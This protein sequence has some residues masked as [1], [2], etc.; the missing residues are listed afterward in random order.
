MDLTK[1]SKI[2][3]ENIISKI[4]RGNST[5]FLD[6]KKIELVHNI[7]NKQHINHYI[8]YPYEGASYG[9]IYSN[10][11]P[12]IAVLKINTDG[13]LT[14]R[15][16]MGSLYSLNLKREIFGDI[17]IKD[18][19]YVIVMKHMAEYIKQNIYEI[20]THQVNIEECS[21]AEVNNYKPLYETISTTVSSERIDV[22]IAKIIGTS[23]SMVE[24]KFR[25]KEI[26]LNYEVAT[27]SSYI[28]KRGDIFSIRKNGK[29]KYLGVISTSKRDKLIIEYQKYIN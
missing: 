27:K 23:R 25:N 15:E 16:I 10:G 19:Y 2:E 5:Y 14:H 3:I 24:E 6:E 22:V 28:L 20:G 21:I 11:T 12:D 1:Q 17:I 7:L 8:F 4:K 18:S 9:L 13:T 26:V 29:Y